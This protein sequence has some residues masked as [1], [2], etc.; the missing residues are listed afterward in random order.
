MSGRGEWH[1][2][3]SGGRVEVGTWTHEGRTFQALG[4]VLDGDRLACYPHADGTVRAWS[5]EI[6]GHYRTL[7][8][9][10]AVFFGHR[11]WQGE[12]YYYMRATLADGSVYA[13]RGFGEGM[14]ARGKRVAS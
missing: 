7:C 8:S 10:P 11:S 13:I 14:I 5:G 12:R 3:A 1:E 9:R 6:L 2:T 4:A